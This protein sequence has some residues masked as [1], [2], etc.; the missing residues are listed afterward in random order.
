MPQR[1]GSACTRPGCAGIVR[2]GVCSACGPRARHYHSEQDD[3]RGTSTQR[4]YDAKWQRVRAIVMAAQPLC[5]HC[6]ERGLTVLAVDIHHV[7]PIRVDAGRRLDLSNLVGL[8]RSCHAQAEESARSQAG[9][10]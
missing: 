3:R 1:A 9:G 2:A 5:A 6:A 8:C 10:K 7:I 4:G